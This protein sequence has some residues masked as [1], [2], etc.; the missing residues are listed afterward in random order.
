MPEL[1]TL[2]FDRYIKKRAQYFYCEVQDGTADF[3]RSY[4]IGG[5][6]FKEA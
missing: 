4:E 3:I 6:L 1:I 2:G 5:F